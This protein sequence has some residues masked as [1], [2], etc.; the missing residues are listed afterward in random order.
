MVMA[1]YVVAMVASAWHLDWKVQDWC[2]FG[3]DEGMRIELCCDSPALVRDEVCRAV[4]RWRSSSSPST[5]S[6]VH[7]AVV[8]G[9][10]W[11]GLLQK[12]E[13]S[14]WEAMAAEPSALGWAGWFAELPL[15]RGHAQVFSQ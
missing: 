8:M 7:A 5:I 13:V 1:A 12:A 2:T 6:F 4:R 14:V 9:G 11:W 3:T 10:G 15:L